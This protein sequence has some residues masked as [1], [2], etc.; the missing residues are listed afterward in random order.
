MPPNEPDLPENNT[1]KDEGTEIIFALVGAVGT[2]LEL[3]TD[4]IKRELATFDYRSELIRIS[5]DIIKNLVELP[6]SNTP[7]EEINTYMSAGNKYRQLSGSNAAL[8]NATA[9]EISNRRLKEKGKQIPL[10]KTAWII[11]SLKHPEELETLRK[12]YGDGLFVVGVYSSK[13]RREEYL[14]TK[15]RE[16]DLEEAVESLIA[17]DADEGSISGHGQHTRDTFHLSDFFIELGQSNDKLKN[18]IGRMLNLIFSNPYLTPT[19]DEFAMFMAFSA[20]TRS[21]DLSRQVG[22]VLSK[23]K[24]I[25][26]TGAN[27]VPAFGG[28]LYWPYYDNTD[29]SIKDVELGRDYM[30]GEDSN[31]K[32]KIEITNQI[33]KSFDDPVLRSKITEAIKNS[34]IDD[35]TEYGRVV[36]AEMEAILA[37]ARTNNSTLETSLF[38]TTFPCHNCAKHIIAAG[39]SRVIYVEPYPKSRAIEFH[40][41]SISD[42]GGVEGKVTFEPFVGVGPR[43]FLNLFSNNLGSSEP[44]IRKN[45]SGE[46]VK[47]HPHSATLRLSPRVLDYLGAELLAS[48]LAH[49][50]AQNYENK[51][52]IKVE[53][54]EK[55]K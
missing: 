12:I 34:R 17:R 38:C 28:G 24:S 19:F 23:N 2:E 20:S 18:Q 49:R 46:V 26:S 48:A 54:S 31:K 29:H 41:D 1:I 14:S 37:C 16:S 21:A 32:S 44:L 55:S 10:D 30:R 25:I 11:R 39:I 43:I 4:T 50:E 53:I 35:L 36:H 33:L 27:D 8:A 52:T 9:A 42:S 3:V 45:K 40:S 22:A 47:W 13:E 15:K 51:N 7:L 6:E 5:T